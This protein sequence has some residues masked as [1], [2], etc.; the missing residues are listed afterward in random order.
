[1]SPSL[2]A[3][4]RPATA[5][6]PSSLARAPI[7]WRRRVIAVDDVAREELEREGLLPGAVVV[8]TARTPLGGPVVVELGRAR[9]AL[10]A[11]VARM[12]AT[13]PWSDA[14]GTPFATGGETD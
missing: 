7:G 2:R 3:H 13:E 9:L 1:M 12:V 10:S 8:V 11:S 4:P 6:E 5:D 14:I